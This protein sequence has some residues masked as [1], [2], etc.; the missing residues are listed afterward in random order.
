MNQARRMEILEE[1]VS[2]VD[3][4]SF[5]DFQ[6]DLDVADGSWEASW[7]VNG[8]IIA[9]HDDPVECYD[10]AKKW[11]AKRDEPK[12]YQLELERL[13]TQLT[14]SRTIYTK[15]GFKKLKAEARRIL[16]LKEPRCDTCS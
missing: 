12:L 6:M 3:G 13:V 14:N 16:K 4:F 2:N 11:L 10:M 8:T 7:F 9:Q 15:E 1:L 5:A